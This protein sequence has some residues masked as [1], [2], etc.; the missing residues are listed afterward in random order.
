MA[1]IL[2]NGDFQDGSAQWTPLDSSFPPKIIS[3]DDRKA[4]FIYNHAF[5]GLRQ[6]LATPA[7]ASRFTIK[8]DVKNAYPGVTTSVAA[9]SLQFMESG[10]EPA[11]SPFYVATSANWQSVSGTTDFVSDLQLISVLLTTIYVPKGKDLTLATAEE[12]KAQPVLITNV[13]IEPSS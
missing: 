13:V 12:I 11:V 3:A 7:Q 2:I 4:A 9:L 8:F 1:N 10:G 6:T 5:S